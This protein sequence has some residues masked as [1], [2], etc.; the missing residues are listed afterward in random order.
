MVCLG[1]C[2]AALTLVQQ[3][4]VVEHRTHAWVLRSVRPF[5]DDEATSVQGLDLVEATLLT[6]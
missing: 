1:F 3:S 6:M 2:I 5:R 4:Q